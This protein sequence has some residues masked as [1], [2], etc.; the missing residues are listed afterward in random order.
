MDM[1][2]DLGDVLPPVQ[3]REVEKVVD[4][5]VGEDASR[6]LEPVG[7]CVAVFYLLCC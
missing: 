2:D 6:V 1:E 4:P 3:G 7:I 5:T